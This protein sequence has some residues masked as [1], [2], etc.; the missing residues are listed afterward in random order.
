MQPN[1]IATIGTGTHHHH[2]TYSKSWKKALK[3]A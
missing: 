2:I 3:M 1:Y